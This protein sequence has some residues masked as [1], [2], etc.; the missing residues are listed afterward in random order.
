MKHLVFLLLLV[1]PKA[2]LA[3]LNL[4]P[5]PSFEDTVYCPNAT[6]QIDACQHWLNFGNSPDYF[7]ACNPFGMSVPNSVFGFQYAHSG[8]AMAGIGLYRRPNAPSG[9]NY[10]EF[11]GVHL[12]QSLI[13]GQKYFFSCYAN[14]AGHPLNAVACNKLGVNIYTLPFD[15]CCPPPI[16]NSAKLYTDSILTDTVNWLRLEGSFIADSAYSY[17]CIGNFFTDSNTDTIQ[18]GLFPDGSYY[19]IDDVCL[20][21]DSLYNQQWTL[22]PELNAML[23]FSSWPNPATNFFYMNSFSDKELILITDMLGRKIEFKSLDVST[24]VKL[25][26]P[27][28]ISAASLL[29]VTILQPNSTPVSFKIVLQP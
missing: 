4:V 21:T 12:N 13:T 3:Q 14:F 6:N 2:S 19:Y 24:N 27:L 15:S 5:N 17:L 25:I 28:G 10:R 1:L 20:T 9:P 29:V 8:N 26:T 23:N 11:I 16:N 22:A 7:N 18:L